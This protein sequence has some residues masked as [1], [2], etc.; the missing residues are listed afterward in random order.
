MSAPRLRRN[1][2]RAGPCH[3]RAAAFIHIAIAAP[4]TLALTSG[5]RPNMEMSA[6]PR[7][8]CVWARNGAAVPAPTGNVG[9]RDQNGG[10]YFDGSQTHPQFGERPPL[11]AARRGII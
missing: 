8:P 9:L 1:Q 4:A 5:V 11:S 2:I 10:S 7:P 6:A 3:L